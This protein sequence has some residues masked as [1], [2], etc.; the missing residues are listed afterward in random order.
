M[1]VRLVL[2][3]AISVAW[4]NLRQAVTKIYGVEVRLWFTAIT[5]TQFHFIFY[6]TRPLPNIFALPLGM[7]RLSLT[8]R[9]NNYVFIIFS[10][11]YAI[12]YWMR[13]Q[14]KPFIICS[15]I[16]IIVFRSELALFLGLLLAVD[17][18]KQKLSIDGYELD[19]FLSNFDR[20]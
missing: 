7:F 12:A 16:S 9:N 10:V 11:L 17:L 15:G 5:I 8:R 2:A 18:V 19:A 20:G 1:T 3:G 6:M 14:S 4:H 13:G